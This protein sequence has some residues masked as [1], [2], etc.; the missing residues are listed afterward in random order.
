MDRLWS[1]V[2]KM[3]VWKSDKTKNMC[4]TIKKYKTD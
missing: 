3:G 2:G 1:K 4:L